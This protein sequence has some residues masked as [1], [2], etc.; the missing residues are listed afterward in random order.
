[1]SPTTPSPRASHG[2][3]FLQSGFDVFVNTSFTPTKP[4]GP[5][6]SIRALRTPLEIAK[7]TGDA[8]YGACLNPAAPH[9]LGLAAVKK[10]LVVA[11]LRRLGADADA[12]GRA[13]LESAAA[14]PRDATLW[15]VANMNPWPNESWWAP[16]GREVD[17]RMPGVG[18]RRVPDPVYPIFHGG[19]SMYPSGDWSTAAAAAARAVEE[20]SPRRPPSVRD[21]RARR[22]PTFPRGASRRTRGGRSCSRAPQPAPRCCGASTRTATMTADAPARWRYPAPR[23][24][25][26]SRRSRGRRARAR[27]SR[28]AAGTAIYARGDPTG[29]SESRVL[30]GPRGT[31]TRAWRR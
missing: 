30:I 4:A 28:L 22:P 17:E 21:G 31:K 1:M 25:R 2:V 29:T 8:F 7:L 23:T 6:P 16:G 24:G 27:G 12:N 5:A 26:R 15:S 11:D 18:P 19:G 3:N 9:Q 14:V 13:A 10:G 20:S